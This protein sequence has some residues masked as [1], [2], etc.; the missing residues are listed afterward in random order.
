[1]TFGNRTGQA[2]IDDHLTLEGGCMCGAV[3][4]TV[5]APAKEVWHCHCSKYCKTWGALFST[6]A[7][8]GR[9]DLTIDQ[10]DDNGGP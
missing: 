7:L 8:V 5:H 1:M 10:S 2:P 9:D 6:T 4:Y 3:R